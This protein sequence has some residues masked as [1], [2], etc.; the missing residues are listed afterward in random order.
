MSNTKK[1]RWNEWRPIGGNGINNPTK[2]GVYEVLRDSKYKG[3][4]V[5]YPPSAGGSIEKNGTW[6]GTVTHWRPSK[7]TS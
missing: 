5:F 6:Y 3:T 2:Q 7:A 1:F 4:A